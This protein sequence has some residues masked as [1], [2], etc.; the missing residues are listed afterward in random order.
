MANAGKK[1]IAEDKKKAKK[2]K[3]LTGALDRKVP[4]NCP[5]KNSKKKKKAMG[6][7]MA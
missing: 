2:K 5:K 7:T 1:K 6:G 4:K 3:Q